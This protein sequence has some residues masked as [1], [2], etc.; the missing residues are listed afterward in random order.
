MIK[1]SMLEW[2][3]HV[4]C[5][6]AMRSTCKILFGKSGGQGL[7]GCHGVEGRLIP[8]VHKLADNLKGM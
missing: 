1:F 7:L 4:A 5:T 2:V 3:E 8:C 6:G